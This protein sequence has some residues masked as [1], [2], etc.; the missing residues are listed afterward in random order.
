LAR[1]ARFDGKFFIA[2][3]T[4]KIYCRPICRSR[5][6]KESNVRY[7]A[8]AAAAAEAGFRPVFALPPRTI[9]GS[10]GL[11]RYAKYGYAGP[12]AHS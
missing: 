11:G 6:S 4:T 1:D 9:S 10:A 5:T 8:S 7:F 3:L 12:T 2:V